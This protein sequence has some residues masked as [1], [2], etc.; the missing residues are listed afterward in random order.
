MTAATIRP[1]TPVA[2]AP[3]VARLTAPNP[4]PMTGAGTNTYLLGSRAIAVIDPG[5]AIEQ[6]L[7]AIVRAASGPIRGILV[8]HTHLDHSPGAMPLARMTGAQVLGRRAPRIARHDRDFAPTRILEDDELLASEEF[9]LRALHTPGHASN[10]LCYLH[11]GLQW[12][13]TGDH[14]IDGSTVVID[15]PD[16]SMRAYLS[17]LERLQHL[18]LEQIAPGHGDLIAAPAAY[19]RWTIAHRMQREAKVIAALGAHGTAPI[20]TLLTRVYDDV[21]ARLHPIAARSLL[22]HL[23]KLEEEGRAAV[24]AN[25][26]GLVH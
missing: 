22:A 4:G 12:L 15:P 2:L 19:I 7:Q 6:H 20:E 11:T 24:S 10:H 23:L 17:S 16:G 9:T 8:T 14:L 5:P 1:G 3:G 25:N 26:W 13:F 21:D 18:Q